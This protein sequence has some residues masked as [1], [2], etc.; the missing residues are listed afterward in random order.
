MDVSSGGKAFGV[1][2]RDRV[3]ALAAQLSS[4]V[5][6]AV[7]Q[8]DLAGTSGGTAALVLLVELE[9]SGSLRPTQVSRLL[10]LTTGGGTK[11]IDRL[12]RSG[13]VQRS[14]TAAGDR[15]AVDV[16]ITSEGR[17]IVES[18]RIALDAQMGTIK[19]LITEMQRALV[20]PR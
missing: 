8:T 3:V 7:E 16:S 10:G 17:A 9:N 19:Q 1:D 20:D 15:R 18:A 11:L 2:R 5:D 6:A 12:E 14:T 4:A 13:F